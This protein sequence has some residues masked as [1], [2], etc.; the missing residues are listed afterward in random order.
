MVKTYY[1]VELRTGERY[2]ST[3]WPIL[4]AQRTRG[5]GLLAASREARAS[6]GPGC[7]VRKGEASPSVPCR[8][9][10]GSS[11]TDR[12][13][14]GTASHDLAAVT[15]RIA[16]ILDSIRLGSE[17]VGC[18]AYE[19]DEGFGGLVVAGAAPSPVL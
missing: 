7:A 1:D 2:G 12:K 3:E 14:T 15:R 10:F 18:E 4:V 6:H 19:A 11:G 9:L 8:R 16:Q 17:Q 5:Y 13:I